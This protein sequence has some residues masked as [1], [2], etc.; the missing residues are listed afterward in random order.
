MLNSRRNESHINTK[1]IFMPIIILW[2]ISRLKIII[3]WWIYW[4]KKDQSV[5]DSHSH[6]IQ[7]SLIKHQLIL[8]YL[9]FFKLDSIIKSDMKI[10]FFC[11][12][13]ICELFYWFVKQTMHIFNNNRILAEFF[14]VK[15]LTNVFSQV[16][17]KLVQ[18]EYKR[19]FTILHHSIDCFV[20]FLLYVLMYLS[21][22]I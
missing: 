13:T 16:A 18:F 3:H 19:V 4:L 2:L 10:G 5:F 6:L 12:T 1:I 21:K 17:T 22:S 20:K 15:D 11:N 9:F 14:Y 7:I 8:I